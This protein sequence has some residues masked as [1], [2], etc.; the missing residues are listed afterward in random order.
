[1]HSIAVR[2]KVDDMSLRPIYK[3]LPFLI[4]LREFAL[5][6]NA[7]EFLTLAPTQEFIEKI[8]SNY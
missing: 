7:G 1:V 6:N 3:V 2:T 5:I 4:N 8:N